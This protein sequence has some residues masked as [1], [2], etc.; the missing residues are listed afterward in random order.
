T[1]ILST[2]PE[3]HGGE[4]ADALGAW[5][6]Q[7]KD[8]RPFLL[9]VNVMDS[10][11]PYRVREQNPFLPPGVDAAEAGALSQIPDDYLCRHDVS[12]RS[13][14]TLR[15]LYLGGVAAADAKLGAVLAQLHGALPR[16]RLV[17]LVTA[18]HGEH[19]GER[20]LFVHNYGIAEELIHVPLLVHGLP[21][22]A[23][24]VVHEPVELA[25]VVPTLLSLAGQPVPPELP[26]RP[27]PTRDPP[28][29]STRVVI[30]EYADLESHEDPIAVPAELE[31][32]APHRTACKPEDH[33]FGDMYALLRPPLHLLPNPAGSPDPSHLPNPT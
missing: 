30:A 14:A 2:K 28:S 21:G 27:L 31:R 26:G 24:A 20:G 8:D 22:A 10:H 29:P 18:D 11:W 6:A 7:R 4:V 33:V 5:L 32:L 13:L 25:D 17:T 16:Q 12:E 23:P 9:F 15:G 3:R 19:L 1:L